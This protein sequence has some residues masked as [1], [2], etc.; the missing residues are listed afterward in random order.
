MSERKNKAIARANASWY[1]SARSC[2]YVEDA[3]HIKHAALRNFYGLLVADVY[4][5]AAK[6]TPIPTVLDLGA[7]EGSATLPFLELGAKVTAVDVSESQLRIL[8]AKCDKFANRL[9]V[10]CEDVFDFIESMKRT[11]RH[12]DNIILNSFLHH[13]PD[14]VSLIRD[15]VDLI[16]PAGQFF[17]FQDPLRYDSLSCFESFFSNLAH[18][19]WRIFKGDV[20]DGI[21]RRI[22]RSRGIYLEESAIDNVEYHVIRNGV[23][24][25]AI[26]ELLEQL[27]FDCR[28]IRYFSTQ[29]NLWQPIGTILGVENTFAVLARRKL[30]SV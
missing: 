15:V 20:I 2:K 27:G 29:S 16:S 12:Y 8:Q 18:C 28:I 30:S 17:S 3:T 11:Q 24:Q 19:S 23:N 6:S 9:E 1:N 14:Y 13:V 4:D 7:G 5:W 26:R 21:K 10:H 25:D 22:R